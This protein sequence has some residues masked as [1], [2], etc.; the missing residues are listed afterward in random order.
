MNFCTD[1]FVKVYEFFSIIL[2]ILKWFIPMI[3]IIVGTFDLYQAVIKNEESILKKK[4][5]TLLKRIFA[6][7]FIFFIP[8]LVLFIFENM[9]PENSV[10]SCI[11][12]CIL[13]RECNSST[14]DDL[15]S[16]SGNNSSNSMSECSI[17]NE[18]CI[19]YEIYEG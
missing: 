5:A 1:A 6:G 10:N 12:K 15:L 11:Y 13:D 7:V 17:E 4:T 16:N 18:D 9:L 2:Y 3:I 19:S 8:N 14:S